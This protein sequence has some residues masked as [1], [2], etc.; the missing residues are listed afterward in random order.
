MK[1][2]PS[3]IGINFASVEK[4]PSVLKVILNVFEKEDLNPRPTDRRLH[5]VFYKTEM[6]IWA[7][8]AVRAVRKKKVDLR[9]LSNF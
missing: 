3:Q 1:I 8:W 2:F 5:W 6:K 9:I 4:Y 7:V